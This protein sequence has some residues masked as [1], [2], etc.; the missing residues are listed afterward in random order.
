[1]RLRWWW[2]VA[3][4]LVGCKPPPELV[5]QE[6]ALSARL[7]EVNDLLA[8]REENEA[9]LAELDRQLAA[10]VP[11]K[12]TL[13]AMAPGAKVT[14]GADVLFELPKATPADVAKLLRRVLTEAPELR[15][16]EATFNEEAAML[17][18]A[19]F[20]P[21][22]ATPY[23]PPF[24]ARRP[25]FCSR[26]CKDLFERA[27]G[28]ATELEGL[29][30]QAGRLTSLEAERQAITMAHRDQEWRAVPNDD[31]LALFER[32]VS[33]KWASTMRLITFHRVDTTAGSRVSLEIKVDDVAVEQCEAVFLGL[34]KCASG[35]PGL[36]ITSLK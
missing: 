27:V 8:H 20:E 17:R 12:A 19:L 33:P 3:L 29:V 2:A 36:R 13:E 6:T 1:M 30:K 4:L 18:L 9:E 10:F 34:A 7:A 24:T 25:P 21:T 5:A 35:Q 32:A 14:V 26:K 31:A 28:E 23:E 16:S 11:K 15:A 22:V